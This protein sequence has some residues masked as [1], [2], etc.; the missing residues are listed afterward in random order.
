[1]C[2]IDVV[3]EQR[4]PCVV[5]SFGVSYDSSY[6]AGLLTRAPHC[7][8]WG[9]DFSVS[10]F[11][12]EIHNNPVFTSKTHFFPYKVGPRDNHQLDPPE[13]TIAELMKK[14]GH[15]FIDVLKVDVETSEFEA[16]EAF[17]KPY[18][19]PYA[20]PLPFGQLEIEIHAWSD[21]G[22]FA[23]FYRWWTML[24]SAGLRPFWTE[25]NLP[26]VRISRPDVVEVRFHADFR[27]KAAD[28][29]L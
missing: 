21:L 28:C 29:G 24:E 12:P 2:G 16:L 17:F 22:N 1:M 26:H 13:Y 18:I 5:Y 25:P 11:A 8:I 10:S 4:P 3:A 15:D 20:P 7:E 14:N 23:F 27:D 9:Y 6:E 19:G